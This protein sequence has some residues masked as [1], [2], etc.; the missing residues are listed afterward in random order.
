[1]DVLSTDAVRIQAGAPMRL[2]NWG[3][4]ETLEGHVRL[5]EPAGF[6]RVS[7]LGV[8]EQRVNVLGDI[9]AAPASLGDAYRVEAQIITWQADDVLRVP[10]SAIFRDGAEWRAFVIEGGR[11][12]LRTVLAG[13]RGAVYTQ[14]MDGLTEGEQVILFPSDLI[15]DGTR[16]RRRG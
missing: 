12:R 3:G 10:N 2:I 13:Q 14:V 5:V 4:E 6:T 9:L 11:A 1:V 16:V 8:D 7:A 15:Q